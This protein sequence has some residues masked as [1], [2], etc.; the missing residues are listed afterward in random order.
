LTGAA[1]IAAAAAGVLSQAAPGVIDLALPR[2]A[3]SGESVWLQ[4][5]TGQ[6]ARGSRIRARACGGQVYGAVSP[7]GGPNGAT[8]ATYELALPRSAI[9]GGRVRLCLE[10]QPPGEGPRAPAQGEVDGVELT[11]P[12]LDD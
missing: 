9:V 5:R 11:F 8:A 10:V 7:F 2:P 6:V 3:V 12:P 1:L 4:I